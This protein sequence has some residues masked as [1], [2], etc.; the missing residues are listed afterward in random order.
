MEKSTQG[1]NVLSPPSATTRGDEPKARSEWRRNGY[2]SFFAGTHG[3]R[4]IRETRFFGYFR[5]MSS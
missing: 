2:K 3:L 5:L 4:G 1:I